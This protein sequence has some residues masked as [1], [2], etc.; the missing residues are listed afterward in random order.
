MD[1][2]VALA[3]LIVVIIVAGVAFYYMGTSKEKVVKIGVL[4]PLTGDLASF[5][6][7][8]QESVKLAEQEI[9]KYL[10][11]KGAG[12]K[13]E[14]VIVDTETKPAVALQ[15]FDTLYQQGIRFFIG[16]M[17]SGE[18]SE[19]VGEI[20]QGKEAVVISQSS[21]APSLA[22]KD[23][24]FRFPPPDELQGEVLA[25]LYKNDGVTHV[26]IVY[27]NDDWGSGLAGFVETY[28]TQ[29]GGTVAAK[30]SYDPQSPNFDNLVQSIVNNV[31]ELVSQGVS[32]ENIGVELISFEEASQIL[33]KASQYDQ[34]KQVKWYGSDGTAL[35]QQILQN[36]DAASFAAL[37]HWKNT[38][39]FGLTDK[40]KDVYCALLNKVGYP[41]DPYSLIAYDAVWVLALAI[42]QAGGPDASVQA[43][44]NAVEDVI[45]SYEGVT[46]TIT[47][48]EYGDRVA[49][50][51]GIFE[52]V[53]EGGKFDWKLTE[54]WK[55]QTKTFETI[56][57]NPLQCS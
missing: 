18:L 27:R 54:L 30:I 41:P 24:V 25:Q 5:G 42:E 36:N 50:D 6:K 1:T 37:V 38:I 15:R 2:K 10:E 35:S 14:L 47:L 46:G 23:T 33:G 3:I 43:V 20:E 21:T 7:T 56:T 31:D 22:L 17:S 34:L 32:P 39:T 53:E 29:E 13:I 52:I 16:P 44:A 11:E 28:F 51:Y 48:N 40:T 26:I 19:I 57:E 8:N 49:T 9:N 45:K 12:Y 55:Y 4:L